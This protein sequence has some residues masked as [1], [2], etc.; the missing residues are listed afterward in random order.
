MTDISA[1]ELMER[2]TQEEALAHAHLLRVQQRI[3][4]LQQPL[5]QVLEQAARTACEITGAAGAVIALR[6]EAPL[7]VQARAGEAP[8][9][10]PEA[11]QAL[12]QRL[13]QLPDEAGDMSADHVQDVQDTEGGAP[14]RH[15]VAMPLRTGP[16]LAG[17]LQVVAAPGQGFAPRHLGHLHVL[18]ES[19]GAMVQLRRVHG[20]LCDSERQYRSLFAEHPQPMWVCE[21][22]SLR[23]LLANHAMA[24]QYG[25]DAHE[26]PS[27]DMR[28]LWAPEHRDEA[29]SAM[30][31]CSDERAARSPALEPT[32]W[33]HM[34]KDGTRIDMEVFVGDTEFDGRPA[35]QILANDITERCRIEQELARLNRAKRL[36][37]ACSETLVRATS[38]SD[39]LHAVCRA[40]V[41]IGGYRM[42]W[43]GMARNDPRKRIEVVAHAG[44]AQEYLEHMQLSWSPQENGGQGPASVCLRSGRTVIV[45]DVQDSPSLKGWTERM[46]QLG[47]HAV[48]CLPLR[49]ARRTFGLLTLYAPQV[50]HVGP[51]ETQLLEAMAADLAFGIQNLRARAEQQRLQAAMVKVATAVSAGT[52]GAFFERLAHHMA[53]TLSA[54]VACVVRLQAPVQGEPLQAATLSHVCGGVAQATGAYTLDGTP[55]QEL[56]RQGQLVIRDHLT[57]RYP[58]DAVLARAGVRSYVGRQL[59]SSDG[60]PMGMIMVMF[61]EPLAQVEFVC[62][63][64]QIFAARASAELQRQMDDARIRHQASLLDR[65]RDAIIVRDL[66]HRITFWNEGA[67]RMYGWSREEALGRSMASLL[68]HDPE[69]FLHATAQVLQHGDWSGEIVQRSRNGRSIEVEGRWTLV[70][71]DQGE[72]ESILA[73]DSDIGPRKSHEREIQ[74]LAF[75]D[76][77]TGLPNRA[78]FMQRMGHALAT[79]RRQHQGGA[80]LFIDLDNFK[81][82][83]DTLGH[84]Q[85]DRLLQLV[86]QRLST[87]VRSV[88]TVARLG[89]DEFVVL[90]EQ[91]TAHAAT[92]AE[93]ANKVGEKILNVLCVPYALAGHQYRSTP[94]I[95]IALF[96]DTPTSMGELLKQADLAMYQAKNAGRSTLRFFD[97]GMQRAVDERAALEADLRNALSQQEFTLHY[98]PQVDVSG[99]ILGVEALLR[100]THPQRG[101]VSPAQF[102]PVAEE[103]GLIL[104][105]GRWVLHRACTLLA[106]W[107]K[108]PGLTHLTMAVNVSSRQFRDPGF[109]GDV[110]RVLAVTGAPSAQLKLELTE[111]L[112]VEDMVSTIA[113]MEALRAHGVGFSLDDFGTGYSSLAY[114]KRMPLE[115]LK[116]DRSF[117]RDLLAD[118]NNAAIVRTIVALAGSLGLSVIA[119]G[120]ETDE[121]RNWLT[122]AG[123]T[124]YQGYFFNRPLSPDRLDGLLR[125]YLCPPGGLG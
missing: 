27:M 11:A 74:R 52:G 72:P 114:L 101:M 73:I 102:I 62:S 24:R 49:N 64:L 113:T 12:W 10:P 7:D 97:P 90:L 89:G 51:Q 104:P 82:L 87:C 53:D 21:R 43:V 107:Q 35:W 105:L 5:E 15:F 103:T 2:Q 8:Q 111:S 56:L 91:L 86:A 84:D 32:V 78:Q 121:Q 4:D 108:F 41:E 85:G 47:L 119:E 71:S 75:F 61:R 118:E 39:L 50:L 123:C 106:A 98:Q 13:E 33:H 20:Q 30:A 6:G 110:A 94:S 81:T 63:A 46:A 124:V 54:Q 29:D 65:A 28:M 125:A 22:D 69:D 18:A 67:E 99:G 48:V 44:A 37:S 83:N 93:H 57:Q 60:T 16:L 112:L 117:V 88:D 55:S 23:L 17:M 96:D 45:R 92:L 120:V 26:L 25:Y 116:I 38:E 109:V 58:R 122:R 14:A 42:G 77:L 76:P 70:L 34:R 66:E 1:I 3:A 40:A 79:A 36:R 59:A 80:L 100:W 115:Q 31:M 19:L 95:G 68:H 9:P